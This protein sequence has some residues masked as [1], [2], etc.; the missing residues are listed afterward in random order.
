M[1]MV[2]ER[3]V[4]QGEKSSTGIYQYMLVIVIT[5]FPVGI[6]RFVLLP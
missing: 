5:G 3:H 1:A 6:S 4:K 2:Q